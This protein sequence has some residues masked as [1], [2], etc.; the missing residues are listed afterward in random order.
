MT[1]TH[2][3][4]GGFSLLELTC[5]LFII[6]TAG[7]GS[8]QLYHVGLDRIMAMREFD[9]ATEVLRS[10]L[11]QVRALPYTEIISREDLSDPTPAIES[12]HGATGS[13]EVI[14]R[15]LG[16]KEVT[17]ALRWQGRH[18]RWITRKLSTRIADRRA[19]G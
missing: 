16:L 13:T 9:V 1:R 7:F 14:E 18:G 3:K 6:T 4:N 8:I 5:A 12:L 17:V 15:G 10:E 11:E 2:K 19:D